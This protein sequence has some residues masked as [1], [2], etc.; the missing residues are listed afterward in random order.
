MRNNV[1]HGQAKTPARSRQG[2][3]Q[4][5]A[6]TDPADIPALTADLG[7]T[8]AR[9]ALIGPG[10]IME[11]RI[12]SCSDHE[13]LGQAAR[14]YLAEVGPAE[15]P[16]TAAFAVASPV[17]GD[18]VKM[19]NN[20]WSFSI[21]ALK[22]ELQLSRLEVINDFTAQ[23]LAIPLL[24]PG[25]RRQIGRGEPRAAAPIGVLG[26]GTGLGMASLVPGRAG[27]MP[28][29]GE[30]GHA[31]MP[32]AEPRE[33]RVLD[34]LR[35]DYGHVSAERVLSGM[36]LSN[37][38][39]ALSRLSGRESERLDAAEVTARA[40]TGNDSV[41]KETVAMFCAM[42]GTVAGNLALTLGAFGGIYIAGGIVPRLGD[43]FDASEFRDRFEAK[44]R[45][46]DYLARIPTYVITHPFPAFLGLQAVLEQPLAGR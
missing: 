9:F 7:A 30:G 43:R 39:R 8:N 6:M 3:E 34:L 4:R 19:T 26:P 42:L 12:L 13:T 10:G 46:R 16:V 23:A 27:W 38:H 24:G 2:R 37:L 17:F 40:E 45:F 1:A 36:G 28:L 18:F 41:S 11:P 15:R 31:T 25:D 44:G 21:A 35:E 5:A 22:T 14:S 32:P 33:S 20:P 29:P